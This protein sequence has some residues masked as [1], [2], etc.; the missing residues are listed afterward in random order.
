MCAALTRPS[1]L[2]H[3]DPSDMTSALL[4]VGCASAYPRVNCRM[5]DVTDSYQNKT[6]W[7]V[8]P[9]DPG[10]MSAFLALL[11]PL[12]AYVF[13]TPIGFYN[14]VP[15]VPSLE[16]LAPTQASPHNRSPSALVDVIPSSRSVTGDAYTTCPPSLSLRLS[17]SLPLS[18]SG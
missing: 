18:F 6:T 5:S 15:P 9:G 1:S 2:P 7:C 3:S 8:N 11:L 4:L 16:M 17:S 13:Q 10:R 12:D 14:A